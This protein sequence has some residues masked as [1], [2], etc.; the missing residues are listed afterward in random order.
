M[1]YP[2]PPPNPEPADGLIPT[3]FS[4]HVDA[5]NYGLFAERTEAPYDCLN[6]ELH[7]GS[8][9]PGMI[10]GAL[11]A[12][13]FAGETMDQLKKFAFYGKAPDSFQNLHTW[14]EEFGVGLC[15]SSEIAARLND[16]KI[17]RL[18]HV[19]S[20][21]Q[22]E[23]SEFNEALLNYI[24]RGKPID[25]VNLMEELGDS[26]WYIGIGCRVLGTTM[27]V[28][29]RQNIAKLYVR[30]RSKFTAAEADT[31]NLD[32]ERATLEQTK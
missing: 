13:A 23:A 9:M 17:Q 18:L 16:L 10:I 26:L 21:L 6:K 24:L 25:D 4:A 1:S 14:A 15:V 19:G 20:G 12:S 2:T 29:L 28:L 5:E 3:M 27:L 32:S 30:F 8:Q 11:G 22:T 7:T 31:R